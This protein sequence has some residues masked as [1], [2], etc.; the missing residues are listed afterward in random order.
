[1]VNRYKVAGVLAEARDSVVVVGIG[2]NVQ[3]DA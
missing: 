1:M 3:P 2:I